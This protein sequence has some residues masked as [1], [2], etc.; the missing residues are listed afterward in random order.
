MGRENLSDTIIIMSLTL[1]EFRASHTDSY[2][3]NNLLG[4]GNI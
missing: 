4:A 3:A 1:G 2:G